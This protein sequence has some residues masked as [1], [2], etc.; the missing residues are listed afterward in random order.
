[1]LR[2]DD[3]IIKVCSDSKLESRPPNIA[4]E[5]IR[6]VPETSLLE[7]LEE[8]ELGGPSPINKGSSPH[9]TSPPVI[10]QVPKLNAGTAV[11]ILRIVHYY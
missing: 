2:A 7:E 1:M 4:Y 8:I 6:L 11:Q 10:T 3:H 5:D 9:V